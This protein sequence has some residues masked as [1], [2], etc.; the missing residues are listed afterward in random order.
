MPPT[1]ARRQARWLASA[2]QRGWP[3][4]CLW[5]LSQLYAALMRLRRWLY[6][7]GLFTTERLPVPVI[8]VGNVVVGGAGKTPTVVALVQHLQAQGWQPG[9]VSR[10]FGR[11]SSA[12]LSVQASTPAALCGDEP[13]LIQRATGVP[14]FVGARRADA[15]RALLRAHPAVDLLLCDD[16]LQHL[17]LW[18]DLSV[19]VF[20]ERGTGNGWQLPAGLLREA[21]PGAY[22]NAAQNTV[23]LR[24]HRQGLAATAVPLPSGRVV[25]DAVRR[26]GDQ[27]R[28]PD[29]S[30]QA[31]AALQGLPLTALAGI[32]RPQAFFEMLR[33]RGL[34]I[35]REVALPDHADASAYAEWAQHPGTLVC[36]EKDAVKLFAAL[37]GSSPG[38][39]PSVWAVALELQVDAAFFSAVRARLPGPARK[40]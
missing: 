24:Q 12:T 40:P 36:T 20:D 11:R 18:R 2:Q 22:R 21:W 29:G 9:V 38:Q 15:A 37:A 14:V 6:A 1:H 26:L 5:P 3:A 7:L 39:A 34:T 16:G 30:V 10:G 35:Q 25:F 23:V 28:A 27:V 33:A 19:V 13:V 32:A 17:A 31:L 8:V 4:R